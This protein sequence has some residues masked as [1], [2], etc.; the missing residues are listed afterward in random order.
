MKAIILLVEK[1]LELAELLTLGLQRY[2]FEMLG[3]QNPEAALALV[4]NRSPDLVLIDGLKD[5]WDGFDVIKAIRKRVALPVVLLTAGVQEGIVLPQQLGV[6][7]CV[8]KPF[9]LSALAAR[10]AAALESRRQEAPLVRS[11]MLLSFS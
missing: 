11:A 2:G 8:A 9:L 3:A 6:D 1:D 7:D 10:I 5:A 4:G